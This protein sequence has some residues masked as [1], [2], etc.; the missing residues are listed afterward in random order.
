VEVLKEKVLKLSAEFFAFFAC[1]ARVNIVTCWSR[2]Y[3]TQKLHPA[4]FDGM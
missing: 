4:V 2:G 3:G 1:A